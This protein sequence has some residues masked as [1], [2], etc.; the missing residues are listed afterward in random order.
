MR[1]VVLIKRD[2]GEF[3]IH[4]STPEQEQVE[5]GF[6]RYELDEA[7]VTLN[8]VGRVSGTRIKKVVSMVADEELAPVYGRRR[9]T[10]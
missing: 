4:P 2:T 5:E 9:L 10:Q 1:L 8:V 3:V 7:V 6:D